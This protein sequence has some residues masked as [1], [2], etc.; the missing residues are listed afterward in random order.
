M[1]QSLSTL[2]T[3]P[4]LVPAMPK[5]A[6]LETYRRLAEPALVLQSIQCRSYDDI[7]SSHH[8]TLG[9][10]AER[11]Q[12]WRVFTLAFVSTALVNYLDFVGRRNTM[13]DEQ[14]AQTAALLIDEYPQ[15]KFDDVAYF[16]RQ[17]KLAH[18]GTLYDLNG[19]VLLDWLHTFLVERNRA[20]CLKCEADEKAAREAD[21][22]RWEEERSRMTDEEKAEQ[23]KKVDDIIRRIEKQLKSK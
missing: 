10:M 9:E 19:A 12:N 8:P 7:V 13:N 21:E 14:V 2:A 1:E 15:L 6:V 5:P 23:D 4:A 22:R 3:V 17:C 11:G 20:Y 18:F 16:F